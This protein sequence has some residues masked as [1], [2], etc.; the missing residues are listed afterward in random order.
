MR[1]LPDNAPCSSAIA[2]RRL[3]RRAGSVHAF[4]G[5]AREADVEQRNADRIA[6]GA[7]IGAALLSVLAMAHH[8]SSANP[9]AI[10]PIVHG[11]MIVLLAITFYGFAHFGL[12]RGVGKPAILAGLVAYA[13]NLFATIGAAAINGFVVTALATR[14]IANRD[15]FLLA[16]ESNQ[17]LAGIGVFATGIAFGLW[18]VDF[19]RRAGLEAKAI[20]ALGLLAGLAPA[21]LLG[22][23]AIRMDVAGAGLAYA[24]FAV[25]G[26][27]VGQHLIRGKLE[28]GEAA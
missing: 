13:I 27:I 18:S 14:G 20:G 21:A 16:W 6:G 5:T 8:P 3:V 7:L 23:G 15:I 11:T 17:A 9:G 22:I 1:F 28:A 26:A 19:L 12:R 4:G 10:G 2:G 24:A 25:W